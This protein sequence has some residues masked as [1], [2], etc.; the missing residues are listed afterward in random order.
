MTYNH[1]IH[2]RRTIRLREYNYSA[3]GAYF[4]TICVH[5]RECLFGAIS[6]GRMRLND[7]G[8]VVEDVW[9]GLPGRFP[10]VALDEYIIMP[11]HYHGIIIITDDVGALLAAPGCGKPVGA[12]L[13][14]PVF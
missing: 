11:N 14:A 10:Q 8:R 4:V 6:G 9:K 12:L 1:D 2:H 5:E 7:A 13:A 3:S